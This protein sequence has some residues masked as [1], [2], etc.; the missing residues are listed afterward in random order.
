MRIFSLCFAF[1]LIFASN[2]NATEACPAPQFSYSCNPAASDYYDCLYL[3]DQAQEESDRAYQECVAAQGDV[4]LVQV[5][6]D[7]S[8][9]YYGNGWYEGERDDYFDPFY[10]T[11]CDSTF[12]PEQTSN[13]YFYQDYDGSSCSVA[14]SP[15]RTESVRSCRYV[16]QRP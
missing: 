8:V 13:T 6:R 9:S 7:T 2:T 14:M 15:T 5:C 4:P 3:R 11:S 1:M 10:G 16:E 12:V